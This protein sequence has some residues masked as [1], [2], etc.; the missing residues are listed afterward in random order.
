MSDIK[1][2]KPTFTLSPPD[3][4]HQDLGVAQFN[5]LLDSKQWLQIPRVIGC[6]R[7]FLVLCTDGQHP[8]PRAPHFIAPPYPSLFFSLLFSPKGMENRLL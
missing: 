5:L 1:G 2:I 4:Y 3:F 6:S 7:H 8:I